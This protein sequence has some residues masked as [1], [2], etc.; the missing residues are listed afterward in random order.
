MT[1]IYID[2]SVHERGNFVISGIVVTEENIEDRISESLKNNGFDPEDSEF[3]SGLN[4]RKYPEML[5]VR[6]D[7]KNIISSVCKIGLVVLPIQERP[8]IGKETFKGLKQIINSNEFGQNIEIYVDENYFRNENV[9]K[10]YAKEIGLKNCKLNLELD[11]KKFK[12]IQLADLVAHSCSTMLLEQLNII[13]KKVKAGSNSG[14]EPDL[15]IE[16]GF[17]LWAGIRYN[18]LGEIDM[19]RFETGDRYPMKMTEP[20]G[21]YISEFCDNKLKENTRERFGEIYM[22]CIH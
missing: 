7:L 5:N 10:E 2:D 17:E 16:L 8:N 13:D 4:Y 15:E 12:G 20:Y 18:L 3:K 9:G 11:S 21:L 22:G 6:N 1:K 14:Y 19:E